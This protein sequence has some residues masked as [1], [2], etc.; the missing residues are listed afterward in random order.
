MNKGPSQ[1]KV[2]GL[3]RRSHAEMNNQL[4]G[5]D[6]KLYPLLVTAGEAAALC[7]LGVRTWWR[8]DAAGMIPNGVHLGKSKRWRLEELRKWIEA[9]C[10]HRGEWN[11]LNGT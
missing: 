11:L 3:T 8:K 5:N 2:N 9:G 4:S 10:P 6:A 7:G 1:E